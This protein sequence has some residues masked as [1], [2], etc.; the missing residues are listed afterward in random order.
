MGIIIISV[1]Y[2][3]LEIYTWRGL[4]NAL[5]ETKFFN[6]RIVVFVY[7]LA[8]L[9]L[10]LYI[11]YLVLFSAATT[12]AIQVA[13]AWFVLQTTPKFIY[14]LFVL[15]G[16]MHHFIVRQ[17]QKRTQV[18]QIDTSE[19]SRRRFISRLGLGAAAL[20]FIAIGNGLMHG[21]DNIIIRRM[22]LTLPRL[23][24]EFAGYKLAHFSDFHLGSYA[25]ST[26]SVARAV[27]MINAE[28]ADC[29][30]FSGD[31]VNNLAEEILPHKN[32]LRQLRA[33]DGVYSVLGNHDYGLYQ[34]WSS[35]EK[36]QQNASDIIRLQQEAGIRVLRNE[37]I[38]LQRQNARIALLGVENWGKPPFPQFGDLP[39]T[40]AGVKPDTCKILISHD[41]DHWAAEVLPKSDVDL[42]LSGHTHGL[43]F[44]IEIPGWRWSPVNL[45]YEHWGGLYHE[46]G[47]YL[48]VSTG[49]G[50]IAFPG[51][52]GIPPEIAVIEL[53]PAT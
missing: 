22:Q 9:A 3:A 27:E 31:M 40:L 34:R 32:L 12:I 8:A 29:I 1:I 42:T 36:R 38:Q 48:F 51:R 19:W 15:V 41:P 35:T 45:R 7:Y 30:V 25:G 49:L 46:A 24:A 43:Q 10:P 26:E 47:R 6:N 2:V 33:R 37:A 20:P 52:V 44:G 13:T 53:Q 39:A 23:P 28:A 50:F 11:L 14:A 4:R 18:Y 16:D 21:R 5:D 17:R